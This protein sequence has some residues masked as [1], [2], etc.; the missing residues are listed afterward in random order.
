MRG[1][2]SIALQ[3]RENGIKNLLLPEENAT[4]AA[5]VAGVDVYPVKDLREALDICQSLQSGKEMQILPLKLEKSEM[6]PEENR[7]HA[8]FAEVRGQHST[9]RAL[10]VASPGGHNIILI[11]PPDSGKTK[12]AKRLPTILPPLEFVES[13]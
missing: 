8:D 5:V 6:K 9:K 3:A 11:G 1:A 4:E 2:L 12:L 13:L 10:E 7:Y